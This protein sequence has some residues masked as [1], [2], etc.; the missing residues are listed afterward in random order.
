MASELEVQLCSNVYRKIERNVASI[1][2]DLVND[3]T[4]LKFLMDERVS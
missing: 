1:R 2:K 3:N 4:R